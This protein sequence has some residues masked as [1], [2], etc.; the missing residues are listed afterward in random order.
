MRILLDESLPKAL[1]PVFVAHGFEV[2]AIRSLGLQGA[3]DT[4]VFRTAQR[5]KATLVTADL[6]FSSVLRFPPGRH[7]GI[8]ILRLPSTFTVLAICEEV[9]RLLQ[10]VR[11]SQLRGG[12]TILAPNL[13][14]LRSERGRF[15]L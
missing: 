2:F 7:H 11:P 9:R 5:L 8:L 3:P 13:I 1:G 14:R 15:S 6:D 12:I 10:R 4:K